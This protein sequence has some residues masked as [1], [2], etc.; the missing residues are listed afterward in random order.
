MK[1]KITDNMAKFIKANA[2]VF[3]K[4][5]ERMSTDC[6]QIA[7]I[8]VPFLSG[9]LQKEIKAEKVAPL[10]HRVVVNK[11]YAAVREFVEAKHYTTPNTG[12]RY[13]KEAGD[14]VSKNALN[15]FKQA[16]QAKKL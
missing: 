7:W 3:D 9:A 16:G 12:T 14:S 15:Y 8:R 5:L 13:L 4:A 2:D 10:K 6:V 11:E 1:V